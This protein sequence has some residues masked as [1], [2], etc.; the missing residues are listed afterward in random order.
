RGIAR[1]GPGITV[2]AWPGDSLLAPRSCVLL[3]APDGFLYFGLQDGLARVDP[4]AGE[5]RGERV[6]GPTGP[7]LALAWTDDG[8]WW[9][10]GDRV[11][12]LG[13]ESLE[14]PAGV[15]DSD[16]LVV[17]M[18]QDTLWV[19][20]TYGRLSAWS[21]G[22][23]WN[24]GPEDGLP[25]ADVLSLLVVQGSLSVGTRQGLYVE[26]RRGC[27]SRFVPVEAGPSGIVRAQA[28]QAGVHWAGGSAGLWKRDETGWW[29]FSLWP[30][31]SEVRSLEATA[32]TLWVTA[33][34]GG[35]AY[36]DGTQ[37]TQPPRDG[38]LVEAFFDGMHRSSDGRFVFAT[39]AGPAIRE[40]SIVRLLDGFPGAF[41]T[42]V[43]WWNQRPVCGTY[44]G[45]WILHPDGLWSSLGVL[46][47][48]PGAQIRC[49]ANDPDG[50]L[51]IG[52]T[53]GLGWLPDIFPPDPNLDPGDRSSAVHE[54]APA[55]ASLRIRSVPAGVLIDCTAVADIVRIDIVDVRGRRVRVLNPG[56]EERQALWDTRDQ[57]GR[58]VPAGVYFARAS[59]RSAPNIC[60]G[61][62]L[63]AR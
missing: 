6:P 8:L 12:S 15:R 31:A 35:V 22:T 45:L 19:G 20:H 17:H 4:R 37:W 23:W 7:V 9:S 16:A 47:G 32:E 55:G 54:L 49:L 53:R 34:S 13:G 52:S 2:Q 41:P 27:G 61:R 26:E 62:I 11:V 38:S 24:H 28:I 42:T 44:R 56:R 25:D 59:T 57:A 18:H 3:A 39:D 48:L 33:G 51:W 50:G 30:G 29:P 5:I 40:G 60:S 10:D 58:P 1:I 21:H 63:M 43:R 46:D 36:H 14:L